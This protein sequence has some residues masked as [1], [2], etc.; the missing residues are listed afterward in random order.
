MTGFA[1]SE[2]E[3]GFYSWAWE[4]RSVNAKSL[5]VR[6]RIASGFDRLEPLVRELLEK[7]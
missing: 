7:D 6:S 5:D 2:G 4:A 3:F 1:R